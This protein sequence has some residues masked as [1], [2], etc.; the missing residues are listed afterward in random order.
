MKTCIDCGAENQNFDAY[1]RK[2]GGVL[3]ASVLDKAPVG[4]ETNGSGPPSF[5]S[6]ANPIEEKPIVKPPATQEDIITLLNQLEEHRIGLA[7]VLSIIFPGLGQIYK[8]SLAKGFIFMIIWLFG[9]YFYFQWVI[10]SIYGFG[11]GH[12]FVALLLLIGWI[13]NLVDARA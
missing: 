2:C 4:E 10:S 3:K 1:C 7:T 5:Y 6:K 8:G 12:F 11:F 9:V 13:V